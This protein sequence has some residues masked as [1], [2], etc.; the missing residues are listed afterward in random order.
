MARI[1]AH[2]RRRW[3]LVRILVRADSG[4]A[5]EEVL[6][7]LASPPAT[8]ALDPD[9]FPR[10]SL[11]H[12]VYAALLHFGFE[13]ASVIRNTQEQ[14]WGSDALLHHFDRGTPPDEATPDGNNSPLLL[15]I[16]RQDVLRVRHV[17]APTSQAVSNARVWF[18]LPMPIPAPLASSTARSSGPCSIRRRE[19]RGFV[20]SAAPCP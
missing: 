4:F 18:P 13:T 11:R 9:P 2:I 10:H 5:R 6:A 15:N 20:T 12:A 17:N 16:S 19:A 3:P 7:A 8:K 14:E 1:V